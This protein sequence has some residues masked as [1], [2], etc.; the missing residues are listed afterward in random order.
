MRRPIRHPVQ[1]IRLQR[2]LQFRR[3]QMAQM[4]DIS[5]PTDGFAD[6]EASLIVLLRDRIFYF[7]I[8]VITS[9]FFLMLF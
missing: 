5:Q 4:F 2:L 3:Q 1:T 8:V 7:I 6:I 9:L